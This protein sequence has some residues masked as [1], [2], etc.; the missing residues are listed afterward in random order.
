LKS[1][2]IKQT[3]FPENVKPTAMNWYLAKMVYRILCGD[4]NHTAQFDEQLRLIVASDEEEAFSKAQQ[5]GRKEEDCFLNIKQQSVH[6]QFI[7]VSELYRLSE[8]IDGAELYSSIREN[9]YPD[10]YIDIVH[11]KAA[12][13]QHKTTHQLLQLV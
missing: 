2:V 6:W 4:G 13:I 12:H 3:L 1:K 10:H 5:I 7:N 9:D 11:Q 8:L